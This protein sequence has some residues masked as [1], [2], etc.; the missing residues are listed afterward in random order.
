MGI[1]FYLILDRLSKESLW[2]LNR[3]FTIPSCYDNGK[4]II[5]S[6]AGGSEWRKL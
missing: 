5:K 4:I 6:S 2:N 3:M 1:I